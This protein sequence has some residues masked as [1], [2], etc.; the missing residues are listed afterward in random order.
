MH[1][2]HTSRAVK[3]KAEER[4]GGMQGELQA[5]DTTDIGKNTSNAI[6]GLTTVF[7]TSLTRLH[8]LQEGTRLPSLVSSPSMAITR[9]SNRSLNPKGAKE[10]ARDVLGDY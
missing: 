2:P 5:A 7:G 6:G 1:N 8:T 9:C 3:E 4:L 10:H